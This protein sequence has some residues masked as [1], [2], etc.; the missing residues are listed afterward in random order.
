MSQPPP[1]RRSF[2]R[3]H[4]HIPLWVNRMKDDMTVHERCL[5]ARDISHVGVFVETHRPWPVGATVLIKQVFGAANSD[6]TLPD[7]ID[8]GRFG[9]VVRN[10]P[11]GM[12]IHLNPVDTAA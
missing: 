2:P 8:H 6:A 1:D 11:E 12:G 5:L 7:W 10:T 9:T 3:S 4:T